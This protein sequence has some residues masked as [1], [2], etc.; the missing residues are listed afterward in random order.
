[1]RPCSS[2]SL[3]FFGQYCQYCAA[4]CH[5]N[6]KVLNRRYT[7]SS[8]GAK[9]I[10]A[11]ER[12]TSMEPK[13]RFFRRK[14]ERHGC[15][16]IL[17]NFIRISEETTFRVGEDVENIFRRFMSSNCPIVC[18]NRIITTVFLGQKFENVEN[19]RS[20]RSDLIEKH[21]SGL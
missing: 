18:K 10:E 13:Q 16:C 14:T 21:N 1:M 12:A 17:L 7:V 3:L 5:R 8:E 9:V 4:P 2:T 15:Y 11:G 19:G 20:F 6:V